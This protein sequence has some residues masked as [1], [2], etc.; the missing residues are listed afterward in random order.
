MRTSL[1]WALLLGLAATATP[2]FAA[3]DEDTG[4]ATPGAVDQS[5]R[6]G[7]YGGVTPGKPHEEK[8]GKPAKKKAAPKVPTI[9]WVGFQK[10]DG[11]SARV[12]LQL[13]Q[14]AQYQQ[15]MAGDTL[16]VFIEGAR[17]HLRNNARFLDTSFFDTKVARVEA[18][19]VGR[20]KSH[21]AG[22]EVTIHFKKGGAA[23]ADA[24]LEPSQDGSTYLFLDFT[25]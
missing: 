25:P 19:A 24:K 22:V 21:K 3:D 10:L 17:I 7:D 14:E 1:R 18:K 5:H 4:S 2:A 20:A 6:E 13:S 15:H 23:Q 12:F 11:G 9:T 8:P 16:V